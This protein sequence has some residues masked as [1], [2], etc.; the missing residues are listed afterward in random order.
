LVWPFELIFCV[1]KN[2]HFHSHSEIIEDPFFDELK[3]LPELRFFAT[4][5]NIVDCVNCSN[6][7]IE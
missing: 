1:S 6:Y 7:L 2:C 4:I 3:D 5:L